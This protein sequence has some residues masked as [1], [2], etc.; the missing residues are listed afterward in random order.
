MNSRRLCLA[1]DLVDDA[2]LIAQYEKW[3]APGAVWPE[4]L[5][6]IRARGILNMEIWRIGTRMAMIMDVDEGY[7][8]FEANAP[9]VK[10][11]EVL[12]SKFQQPLPNT[13][14]AEKWAPMTRIFAL[15]DSA[16]P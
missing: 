13:N 6:D 3:H 16:E 1:L 7:P 9:R 15:N 14:P 4:I 11:W 10:E 2:E 12:M 5:A 8:R